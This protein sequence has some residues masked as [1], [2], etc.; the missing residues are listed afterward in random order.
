MHAFLILVHFGNSGILILASLIRYIVHI[1]IPRIGQKL[2]D[3]L[4]KRHIVWIVRKKVV[5]S[6]DKREYQEAK[7]DK[8]LHYSY[9][10]YLSAFFYHIK[11]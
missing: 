11:W 5:Y 3:F 2:F 7:R 4:N 9:C 6:Q 1:F 10:H 8:N